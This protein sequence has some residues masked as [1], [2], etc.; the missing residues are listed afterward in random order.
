VLD[1]RTRALAATRLGFGVVQLDVSV[2]NVVIQPIRTDLGGSV[3]SPGV[4][5]GL[6]TSLAIGIG[7][8]VLV[9]GSALLPDR[10]GRAVRN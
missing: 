8:S 7:L 2:V 5:A 4:T 10:L 3:G 6:H 9:A 1:R